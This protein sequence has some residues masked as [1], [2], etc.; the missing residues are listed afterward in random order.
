MGDDREDDDDGLWQH[1]TR[2]VRPIKREQAQGVLGD[3]ALRIYRPAPRVPDLIL[4]N[5]RDRDAPKTGRATTPKSSQQVD[6]RTETRLR[7]GKIEVEARLDLHGYTLDRAHSALR[8]FV[9]RAQQQGMRC[10]LV[11]TGPGVT[12]REAYKFGR[13]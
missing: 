3:K 12:V 7:R 8:A 10:V 2:D 11:V 6:R 1:V 13:R 9:A 4:P 5:R